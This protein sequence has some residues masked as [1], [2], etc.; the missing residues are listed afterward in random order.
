MSSAAERWSSQLAGWGIPDEI[1]A[2]APASPW[3]LPVELFARYAEA[4][5]TRDTPSIDR[6]LEALGDGGAVLDVGCGAGATSVPL[7][8]RGAVTAVCGVDQAAGM[9]EAFARRMDDLGVAHREVE[10]LW[11]D[12]SAA[13]ESAD[14]VVCGH[15]VYNVGDVVPFAVAL[16][17]KARRRVVIEL[18]ERHPRAW[19]SPLWKRLWNL[20]RPDGPTPDDALAA[21]REGGIDAELERWEESWRV[22]DDASF[23]LTRR[24]LCLGED[25]DDE[26]RAALAS[27]PRPTSRGL[28]AIWW[29][30][31]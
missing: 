14:V 25:R 9:L 27:H 2:A 4:A 30:R 15:V 18:T 17:G 1:V 16:G 7:V 6:A 21:L 19:M 29:D 20:D 28:A 22:P 26:L 12:A 11:P 5:P 23:E 3:T 10:G 24:M 13:V 8:A 31:A